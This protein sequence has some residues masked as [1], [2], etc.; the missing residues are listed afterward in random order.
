MSQV[1]TPW[2]WNFPPI[3][4]PPKSLG[5]QLLYHVVGEAQEAMDA[6]LDDEHA[7]R[8][9]EELLDAI[10]AAETALRMLGVD[11]DAAKR[12]VIAK[13]DARGYYGRKED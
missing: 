10:H 6:Y 8:I 5:K 13:N 12:A 4:D 9:A 1:T 11:V 3:A 2:T 7:D